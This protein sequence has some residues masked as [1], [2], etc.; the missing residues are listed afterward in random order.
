MARNNGDDDDLDQD[1][2]LAQLEASGDPGT[3][4]TVLGGGQRS[5]IDGGPYDDTMGGRLPRGSVQTFGGPSDGLLNMGN[6]GIPY[7]Y[8][9]AGGRTG[10]TRPPTSNT[11][12]VTPLPPLPMGQPATSTSANAPRMTQANGV[13]T[14]NEHGNQ[15]QLQANEVDGAQKYTSD[16]WAANPTGFQAGNAN[17]LNDAYKQFTGRDGDAAGLAAHA[18]N[19]GGFAG[20]IAAI[21]GSD[22]AKAYANR[23]QTILGGTT[24]TPP[25]GGAF[26]RENRDALK[27]GNVGRM[28][29]FN[30]S[31][32]GGDVKARNS[33]KNTFG[34]IASRYANAPNSVEAMMADPDFKSAFPNAKKVPGGAGD[35]IDFG[36][37]LSDFE[38]GAPV[39][40]VDVL[41]ASDPRN[42]TANGW[43]WMPDEGGTQTQGGG[44]AV[45]QPTGGTTRPTGPTRPTT[46]GAPTQGGGPL[47]PAPPQNADPMAAI[48]AEIQALQNGGGSP[49]EQDALLQLLGAV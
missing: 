25:A 26:T 24:T 33:V 18:R 48:M 34:R 44:P 27:Y 17:S 28:E 31:D 22:E 10:G 35:K 16:F 47:V 40:V 30:T 1:A 3:G 19:P 46:T 37:V 42:N 45:P 12:P 4:G 5:P 39:G 6:Q 29:G 2:L 43:A 49:M 38:T 15:R 20:A 23:P 36:G 32:Y 9:D 41:T 11:M 21:S 13:W 7:D 14:L 8:P